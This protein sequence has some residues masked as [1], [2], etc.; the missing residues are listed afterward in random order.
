MFQ[1]CIFFL[2]LVIENERNQSSKPTNLPWDGSEEDHHL[3]KKLM[4]NILEL[5]FSERNFTTEPDIRLV[6]RAEFDFNKAI[7][8]AMT[9]LTMDQN[10]ARMVR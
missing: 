5:S 3:S 10:L 8:Q 7:P 4:E 6:Q 9:L 1:L 2:N